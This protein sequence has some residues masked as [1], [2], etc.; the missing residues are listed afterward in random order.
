MS[1]YLYIQ[2]FHAR[3]SLTSLVGA[4]DRPRQHSA[5]FTQQFIQ[6]RGAFRITRSTY[7]FSR[8]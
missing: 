7:P 8:F 4:L 3:T 5:Q 2:D 1:H 6:L